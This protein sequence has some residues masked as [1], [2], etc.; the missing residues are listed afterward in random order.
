M[1]AAIR[2]IALMAA[3]CLLTVNC[4]SV[5]AYGKEGAD[6]TDWEGNSP[7][8]DTGDRFVTRMKIAGISVVTSACLLLL[9][10][11]KKCI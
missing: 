8:P 2:C 5:T 3:V 4:L 1:K 7:I 6:Y 9:L 11:H 10:N